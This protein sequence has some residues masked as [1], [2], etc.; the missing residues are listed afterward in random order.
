VRKISNGNLFKR[1]E[2]GRNKK[3]KILI[4]LIIIL[5][6]LAVVA[7]VIYW[8]GYPLLLPTSEPLVLLEG[9]EEGEEEE[10]PSL[11]NVDKALK[12]LVLGNIAFNTPKEIQWNNTAVIELLLSPSFSVDELKDKIQEAG[13]REGAKIRVADQMS[14]VLKSSGFE[15]KELTPKIQAISFEEITDWKWEITPI[16]RGEQTLY[17]TISAILFVNGER[18][19]RKIESYREKIYIKVTFMQLLSFFIK[20]KWN[21]L[22]S[23]ILVPLIIWIWKKWK[24]K[25]MNKAT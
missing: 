25:K 15:I 24:S 23:V 12:S 10:Y 20:D 19:P 8:W 17:L 14:A 5:S 11:E 22:W 16:K 21:W 3:K 9:E 7:S 6:I 18:T 4:I 13:E 1:S 2:M